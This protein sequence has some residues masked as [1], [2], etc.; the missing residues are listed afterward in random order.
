[1]K[2]VFI[3]REQRPNSFFKNQ[4]EE[5][6]FEVFAQSLV[7]LSS[8]SVSEIPNAEWVFFYSKNGIHYF[9][10]AAQKLG[11]TLGSNLR[12]GCI[13][14]GT[15]KALSSYGITADFIGTGQ[16]KETA[17]AFLDLARG[18][19]VLFPQASSSRQ[20]V[21]KLIGNDAQVISLIVYENQARELF[22][23]PQCDILVF[24]SPLNVKAYLMRYS[25]ME[26]QKIV[27]IGQTT[28][29]Y[30]NDRIKNNILVA[31]EPSERALVSAVLSFGVD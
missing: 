5:K 16:P 8:C 30:L 27:A 1:M 26:R 31:E 20:S 4:L 28:K 10:E 25:I 19:K 17:G 21:Q 24:T 18:K 12:Y 22:E 15:A 6:G 23:L 29:N 11:V 3:S 7:I 2:R 9:F 13:G 14:K